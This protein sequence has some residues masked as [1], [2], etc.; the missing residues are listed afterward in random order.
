MGRPCKEV[1][2]PSSLMREGIYLWV[3]KDGNILKTL[4][5]EYRVKIL[6]EKNLAQKKTRLAYI[7]PDEKKFNAVETLH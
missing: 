3:E 6:I 5:Q 1:G 2:L 7:I 4:S